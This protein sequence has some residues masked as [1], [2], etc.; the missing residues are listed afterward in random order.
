MSAREHIPDSPRSTA[1]PRPSAGGRALSYRLAPDHRRSR[2]AF[3]VMEVMM[4]MGIFVVGFT[5][6]ISLFPAAI[7]MQRETVEDLT[8]QRI[9]QSARTV[10]SQNPLRVSE[11]S[12]NMY[13]AADP[14]IYPLPMV[15]AP[16][17]ARYPVADRSFPDDVDP[18]DRRYFWVPM[19]R[20]IRDY[21]VA[22][23]GRPED[24]AVHIFIM[25][26][27][28]PYGVDTNGDGLKD[29]FDFW[30]RPDVDMAHPDVAPPF[31]HV[32]ALPGVMPSGF[33][34]EWPFVPK[35]CSLEAEVNDPTGRARRFVLAE[36]NLIDSKVWVHKTAANARLDPT[37][38]KIHP[39]D[40]IVDQWGRTHTVVDADHESIT[41]RDT[42]YDPQSAVSANGFELLPFAAADNPIYFWYV[43]AAA[44]SD[45]G[46]SNYADFEIGPAA[47]SPLRAVVQIPNVVIP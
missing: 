1:D 12:T 25:R 43:P 41:L 47:Q 18:S 24:W 2:R 37:H 42:L 29:L 27:D 35:V 21:A 23:E 19:V 26:V 20:K 9:T 16:L 31:A 14:G 10:L 13:V 5:A 39:G 4:A 45:S 22:A 28:K 15:G 44:V 17:L 11:L 6:V 8:I 38:Y 30:Y 7:V 36:E 3:T 34:A 32:S 46:G 33:A 40:L